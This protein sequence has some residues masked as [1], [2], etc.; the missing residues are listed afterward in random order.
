[1]NSSINPSSGFKISSN[2][3]FEKNDFIEGLN[4]SDAGT[5]LEEFRPNNLI[6]LDLH[7]NI[8]QKFLYKLYES[9]YWR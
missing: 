9:I 5:L 4:L 6:R 2:I 8:I 7:G 1:M 3:G